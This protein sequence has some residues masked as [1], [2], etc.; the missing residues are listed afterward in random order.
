MVE[1][2]VQAAGLDLDTGNDRQ[3]SPP[4]LTIYTTIRDFPVCLQ[5][6]LGRHLVECIKLW[7]GSGLDL[8]WIE[9]YGL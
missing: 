1:I 9:K 3:D 8:G 7:P 5:G 4:L 6:R 2:C